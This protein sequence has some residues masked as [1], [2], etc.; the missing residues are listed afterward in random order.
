MKDVPLPSLEFYVKV[1]YV[2]KG[3]KS[4]TTTIKMKKT[5]T[6]YNP[7][8]ELQSYMQSLAR[9]LLKKESYW[10]F[11]ITTTERTGNVKKVTGVREDTIDEIRLSGMV[12]SSYVNTHLSHFDKRRNVSRQMQITPPV[13][14]YFGEVKREQQ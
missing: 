7:L 3:I 6:L 13:I 10:T 5:S 11:K 4:K 12:K 14:L 9:E 8:N 1:Q 2:K